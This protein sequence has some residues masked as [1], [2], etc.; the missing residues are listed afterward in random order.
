MASSQNSL[1]SSNCP[2]P[3]LPRADEAEKYLLACLVDWPERAGEILPLCKPAD[4]F[5][6]LHQKLWARFQT[7]HWATGDI[8]RLAAGRELECCD[9]LVELIEGAP[10]TA[11]AAS[12]AE[13]VRQAARGRRAHEIF[14]KAADAILRGRPADAVI[15]QVQLALEPFEQEATA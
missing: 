10:T 7:Q 3:L 1:S 15:A 4:F 11:H 12:R 9:F 2:R 13:M 5:E 14:T 8:D 6:P